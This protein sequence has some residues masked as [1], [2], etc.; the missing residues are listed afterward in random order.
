MVI[1]DQFSHSETVKRL[2]EKDLSSDAQGA[3]FLG[4]GAFLTLYCQPLKTS[5]HVATT[6]SLSF[7]NVMSLLNISKTI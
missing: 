5:A 3:H 6:I 7:Q 4:L 1:V 2:T